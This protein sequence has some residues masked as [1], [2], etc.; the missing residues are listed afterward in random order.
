MDILKISKISL[1]WL[2]MA[3]PACALAQLRMPSI[4]SDDMVIQR[5]VPANVWGKA[6]AGAE[7]EVEFAGQTVRAKADAGGDWLATL[8][9]MKADA[10]GKTL[11][12]RQDGGGSLK[13]SNVLVGEVWITSGQSN[14]QFG[15]GQLE[16]KELSEI[17]SR[18]DNPLVR[19]I[20]MTGYAGM[21]EPQFDIPKGSSKWRA[22]DAKCVSEFSA[23]GWLFA[24]RLQKDLGVPV[25]LIDT[26]LG[27]SSMICWVPKE[28]FAEYPGWKREAEKFG[29]L[30]AEYDYEKALK[31]WN[32]KLMPEWEKAESQWKKDK[33]GARPK[34]PYKP[35][36]NT[37]LRY[38]QSPAYLFNAKIA[39]I[40]KF[41]ARGVLWYQGENDGTQ[42]FDVKLSKM[43]AVWRATFK[44]P[45]MPFLVVQMPSYKSDW[46]RK[47]DL[48]F[49]AFQKVPHMGLA[50]AIDTGEKGDIHPKDKAPIARRLEAI[51]LYDVYKLKGARYPYGPMFKSAKF[52]GGGAEVEFETGSRGLSG[53]GRPRGFEIKTADGRWVQ[54]AEIK[55]TG[56]SKIGLSAPGGSRITGVRYLRGAY[57]KPLVWLRNADGEPAFSFEF[58]E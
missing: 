54:P 4:F 17:K 41:A 16:K 50:N 24:E 18:A 15:V 53:D 12:V 23:I 9:P 56:D 49:E 33:S 5:G 45:E 44:N 20:K 28:S 19:E 40:S 39:P 2:A 43:I 27:G 11:T 46:S 51:A 47:R 1:A 25:G 3:A 35:T 38:Y 58:Q 36:F 57:P 37:P 34:R 31:N 8:P 13:F 29:K 10:K 30:A 6:D 55:I 26:A 7:I 22:A 14:M 48:Q 52:D 32:E 21:P 42:G